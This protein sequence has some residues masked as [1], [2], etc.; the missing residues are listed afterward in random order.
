MHSRTQKNGL[1]KCLSVCMLLALCG[2]KASTKSIG[3][4]LLKFSQNLQIILARI[5]E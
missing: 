2:P 5:D 4:I 1:Q 3:P